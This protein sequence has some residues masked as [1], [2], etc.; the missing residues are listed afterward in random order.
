MDEWGFEQLEPWLRAR[1]TMPVGPLSG[2]GLGRARS[3]AE[4]GRIRNQ[5]SLGDEQVS[6]IASA[7]CAFVCCCSS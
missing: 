5:V 3:N 4:F 7:A 1:Q 2:L 6:G